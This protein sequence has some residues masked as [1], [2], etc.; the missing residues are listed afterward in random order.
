MVCQTMAVAHGSCYYKVL[1]S[2]T[3]LNSQTDIVPQERALSYPIVI[4]RTSTMSAVIEGSSRKVLLEETTALPVCLERT[5][6]AKPHHW[7]ISFGVWP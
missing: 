5:S 7:P 4:E 3:S 1:S 6:I 2:P